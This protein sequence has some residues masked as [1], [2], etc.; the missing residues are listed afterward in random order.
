MYSKMCR[1]FVEVQNCNH[2]TKFFGHRHRDRRFK[3]FL[4][5]LFYHI[6]LLELNDGRIWETCQGMGGIS[7]NNFSFQFKE[8]AMGHTFLN[9]QPSF[10]WMSVGTAALQMKGRRES[11]I[12]VWFWFIHSQKWKTVLPHCFYNWIIMFCLPNSHSCNCER[13]IYSQDRSSYFAAAK[14]ADWCWEYIEIAHRYINVGIGDKAAHTVSFLGIHKSDFRHKCGKMAGGGLEYKIRPIRPDDR[15]REPVRGHP[16]A[17]RR[18]QKVAGGQGTGPGGQEAGARRRQPP[19]TADRGPRADGGGR[20]A[21]GGHGGWIGGTATVLWGECAAASSQTASCDI[22]RC[23]WTRMQ[24][25]VQ[26]WTIWGVRRRLRNFWKMWKQNCVNGT[27]GLNRKS[28][29]PKKS[30]CVGMTFKK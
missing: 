7:F 18:D 26:K 11:N 30:L 20:E 23:D 27:W 2:K 13:F 8:H 16:E 3:A 12:N 29:E 25:D 6:A 21:G 9:Q 17:G 1:M 14:Y 4:P 24:W 15:T 28:W 5:M 19:K 10:C 22:R